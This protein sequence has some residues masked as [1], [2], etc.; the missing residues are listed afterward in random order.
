MARSSTEAENRAVASTTAELM[1]VQNLHSELGVSSCHTPVIYYCDNLSATQL[2]TN[3]VF[4]SRMK[5]L[6]LAFYFIREQVKKGTL[7][8][9]HVPTGDQLADFLTK[10]LSRPRL[11]LL[12]SKIGLSDKPSILRGYVED[13]N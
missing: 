2:S 8:V 5:H 12:L 10:S 9:V 7:R 11:D 3:L 13:K 4:H 1:W 6:A